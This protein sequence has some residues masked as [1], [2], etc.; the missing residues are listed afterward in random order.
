MHH[1]HHHKFN[2]LN[3]TAIPNISNSLA[4]GEP[5][6]DVC[7]CGLSLL[8]KQYDTIT[9][10]HQTRDKKKMELNFRFQ[11]TIGRTARARTYSDKTYFRFKHNFRDNIGIYSMNE[12][13]LA[14]PMKA[15]TKSAE[16][17][18][19]YYMAWKL[20]N[21]IDTGYAAGGH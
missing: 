5:P 13:E 21:T 15:K 8:L 10:Q 9:N 18:H 19:L 1:V 12:T 11:F 20:L 7:M 17:K 4:Y 6:Y 2:T 3:R 14:D 16:Q